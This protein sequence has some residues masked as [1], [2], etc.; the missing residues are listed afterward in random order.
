[1]VGSKATKSL[2]LTSSGNA[3]LA[4]SAITVSGAQ[5]SDGTTSLPVTL[6]PNQQL[7]LT[8]TYEPTAQGS[9]SGTLTVV[10]NDSS[11]PATVSLGGSGTTAT[12]P[13]LTVNPT[14]VNFGDVPLNATPNKAVTVTSSGTAPVTITAANVTGP[15]FSVSGAS[16]PLTLNPNQTATLQVQ[17]DPGAAGAALGQLSITSDA[18]GGTAKIPLN[19]TG[20]V[21]ASAQLTVSAKSLA[22]DNVAVNSTATLP[23]TLTSSGTAPVTVSSVAVSGTGFAD[24]GVTFPVTLNP[25]QTVTLNVQFNPKATGQATGQLTINSNSS[26]GAISLVQLSGTGTSTATAQLQVSTTSLT[27]GDVP[28]NSTAT[29]TLTLTSSGTAPV[30]VSSAALKGAGFS[31]SGVSFPVTLNPNQSATLNVQFDPTVA[32]A[33]TGQLSISS[34]SSSGATTQVQLSGTATATQHEIDLSWD[35]PASSADP[36]AGY[37]IYRSTGSGG[38]FSKLNT[39]PNSPVSYTDSAVQSG[40]TYVY[41]V[42]SVDASGVES[43]ASNQIT[44]SVP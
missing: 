17:F 35:A 11:G 16:F 18:S 33:V 20:T 23:V 26:T 8:V 43:S 42:K 14:A 22:F 30:T 3:P 39:S 32:G 1:M 28:V 15:G 36:V 4:I 9:D 37:N 41:E 27:F 13:Q 19:G 21:S 6:Q 25:N 38:A 10:S 44:L 12:S 7:T 29:L 31:D 40:T 5:F 34:N 2:T 24:S